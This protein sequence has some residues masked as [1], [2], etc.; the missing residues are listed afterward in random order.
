VR[1]QAV[2]IINYKTWTNLEATEVISNELEL[3]ERVYL[4][5]VTYFQNMMKHIYKMNT[6]LHD[7]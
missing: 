4:P 6:D 1:I 7:K 5:R 2:I 3:K